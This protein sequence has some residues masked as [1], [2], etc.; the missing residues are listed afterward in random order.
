MNRVVEE[1]H[2]CTVAEAPTSTVY[3]CSV[4]CAASEYICIIRKLYVLVS[5]TKF[6]RQQWMIHTNVSHG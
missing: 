5:I 6:P 4:W 3:V 1:P 2:S